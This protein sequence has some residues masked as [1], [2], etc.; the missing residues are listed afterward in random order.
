MDSRL[1]LD[2]ILCEII[3]ITEP[4]GDRH[5]YFNPPAS[6]LM[7][8]PAIRYKRKV[9]E[10]MYANNL[11]YKQANAY[12]L[13][14]IYE[15]PD[16]DIPIKVSQLPTCRHERHYVADNLNHDVFTLYHN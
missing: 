1:E 15:D 8:Y 13:T 11:V 9:I 6:V 12:E 4:D 10:N 7:K 2:E 3:N 14:V 5:T 16:S